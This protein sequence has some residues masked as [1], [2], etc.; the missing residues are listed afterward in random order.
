MFYLFIRSCKGKERNL[1]DIMGF[2]INFYYLGATSRKIKNFFIQKQ[3]R[4]SLV[5]FDL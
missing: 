4:R 2:S 1:E 3:R 5:E